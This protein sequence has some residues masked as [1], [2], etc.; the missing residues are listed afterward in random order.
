MAGSGRISLL[1]ES[2]L[3]TFALAMR[4]LDSEVRGQINKR[5]KPVAE[6]IWREATRGQ[7]E[8]R[9]QTRLADS[10]RVGVTNANVFLRAGAIGRLSS[11]TPISVLAKAIEHGASP[12]T[13]VTT[14]SRTGTTY[15][16]RLGG[17]FRLPRRGGYVAHPAA[18]QVISRLASLW[19]QTAIRTVHETI[20]KAK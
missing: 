20:E 19:I 15:T 3:R 12:D 8:N 1:I 16:R 13:K 9:M 4:G 6:P 17:A 2:P 11:G 10:A 5:T 18:R 14:R 7:V